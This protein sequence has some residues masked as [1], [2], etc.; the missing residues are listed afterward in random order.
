M[1]KRWLNLARALWASMGNE[2]L[3]KAGLPATLDHRSHAARGLLRQPGLHLGPSVTWLAGQGV[4][5]PR[6]ARQDALLE[7]NSAL[8]DLEGR[9]L[10]N[11][12]TLRLIEAEQALLETTRRVWIA[13]R[14]QSWRR[15]LEDHPLAADAKTVIRAAVAVAF[16]SDLSRGEPS[17]P[18]RMSDIVRTVNAAGADWDAATTKDGV[19]LLRQDS[20]QVI[21]V[22]AGF[23]ATDAH[24]EAAFEALLRVSATR[25]FSAPMLGVQ[26]AHENILVAAEKR[27]GLGWKVRALSDIRPQ[28]RPR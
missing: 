2:A 17:A 26:K 15:Q 13:M 6:A 16:D 8:A 14:D 4:P 23:V 9:V 11:R 25:S 20:D 3:L 27:V 19:W 28:A 1:Q 22:G 7:R 10:Q 24:D 18:F 12:K 5:S 21:V